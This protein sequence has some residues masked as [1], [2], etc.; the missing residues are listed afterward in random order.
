[1][2]GQVVV[3]AITEALAE[4]AL[5]VEQPAEELTVAVYISPTVNVNPLIVH[6]PLLL[7]VVVQLAVV[8]L[9]LLNVMLALAVAVPL[10]DVA[11]ESNFPFASVV[12]TGG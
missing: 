4:A 5:A 11:V 12:M 7:A 1:M 3:G 6:A 9:V 10:M 8:G 2:V